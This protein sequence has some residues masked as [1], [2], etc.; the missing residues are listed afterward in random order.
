MRLLSLSVLAVLAHA[1]AAIFEPKVS[2]TQFDGA[3]EL[4]YFEDTDVSTFLFG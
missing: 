2:S 4:V 3:P 1:A